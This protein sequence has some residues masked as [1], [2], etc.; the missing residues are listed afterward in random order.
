MIISTLKNQPYR[1]NVTE[2]LL[3]SYW[4]KHLKQFK[5]YMFILQKV[6]KPLDVFFTNFFIASEIILILGVLFL[7]SLSRL[8]KVKSKWLRVQKTDSERK[9]SE[10][11]GRNKI[12]VS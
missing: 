6:K 5:T 7:Y 3:K 11:R 12:Q 1:S 4:K 10:P 8:L 9:K 2:I